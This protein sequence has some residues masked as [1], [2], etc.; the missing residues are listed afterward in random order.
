MASSRNEESDCWRNCRKL[1]AKL[2]G[3]EH[4]ALLLI[5]QGMVLIGHD[6]AECLINVLAGQPMCHI[7]KA[8]LIGELEDRVTVRHAQSSTI[9]LC[10][11]RASC[12]NVFESASTVL[13]NNSYR[14]QVLLHSILAESCCCCSL[15][16]WGMTGLV[17]LDFDHCCGLM[18][19]LVSLS[20]VG[21]ISLVH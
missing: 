6:A 20:N 19:S 15:T 21:V 2:P 11:F 7:N 16:S 18:F 14:Q 5:A 1:C 8:S 10:W 13:G 17:P 9:H 12:T 4:C 3:F